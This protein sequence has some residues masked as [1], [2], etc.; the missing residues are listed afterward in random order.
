MPSV[1]RQVAEW[2]TCDIAQA[3]AEYLKETGEHEGKTDGEL[4]QMAC[5]DPDLYEWEWQSL[6]DSLTHLMNRNPHGGWK[7]EVRNFGWRS[8]NGHKVF[9]ATTGNALLRQVLPQCECTF[10]VFRYGRGLAIQNA[11]HD[12][13]VG[14]EWYYISPCKQA[15]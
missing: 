12:S 15:A 8:L 6:C 9:R 4:F 3:Q 14:N 11:H 10:K 1:G 7:A 2:D 5:A 13:P